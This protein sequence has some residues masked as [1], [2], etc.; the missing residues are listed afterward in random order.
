MGETEMLGDGSRVVHIIE[1]AT[2]VLHRAIR[3]KL[4]EAAVVPELHGQSH[5]GLVQ[6]AQDGR[7]RGRIHAAGHGYGGK[8]RIVRTSRH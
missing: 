3:M 6:L 4:G 1:R 5:D 7:D 2:A 8:L